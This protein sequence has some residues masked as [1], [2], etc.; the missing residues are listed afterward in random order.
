VVYALVPISRTVME[1]GGIDDN[2]E[3]V[4]D[5]LKAVALML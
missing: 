2:P 5:V 4:Q 1:Q 3:E